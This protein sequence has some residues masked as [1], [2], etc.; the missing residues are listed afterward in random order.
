MPG[1]RHWPDQSGYFDL[2]CACAADS[3]KHESVANANE[4]TKPTSRMDLDPY[5]T[6]RAWLLT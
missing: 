5:D 4:P 2:S 6:A 3:V 1:R